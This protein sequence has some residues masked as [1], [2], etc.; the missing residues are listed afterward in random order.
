MLA[1]L[2]NGVCKASV[3]SFG[4]PA[5]SEIGNEQ[6]ALSAIA[7][8]ETAGGSRKTDEPKTPAPGQ[9]EERNNCP[10]L[11]G[12]AG[13]TSPSQISGAAMAAWDPASFTTIEYPPYPEPFYVNETLFWPK[14]VIIELL[15]VPIS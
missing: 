6:D 3:L 10:F 8:V 15:K 13:S 12:S 14:S 11:P 4:S 2:L 9:L 7:Q 5:A 1:V